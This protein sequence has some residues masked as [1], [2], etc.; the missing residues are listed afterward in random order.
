[1]ACK[2]LLVQ[3]KASRR[4]ENL[5]S[6]GRGILLSEKDIMYI[7]SS[8]SSPCGISRLATAY[9]GIL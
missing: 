3:L 5:V 1:M 8:W 9:V 2:G 7:C 4:Q 6:L